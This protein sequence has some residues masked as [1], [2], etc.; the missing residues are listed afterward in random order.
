MLELIGDPLSADPPEAARLAQQLL[1][2][3]LADRTVLQQLSQR[4]STAALADPAHLEALVLAER[5]RA[6]HFLVWQR[7]DYLRHLIPGIAAIRKRQG[8][9]WVSLTELARQLDRIDHDPEGVQLVAAW[10]A[11]TLAALRQA[12]GAEGGPGA[13]L[14]PVFVDI[15]AVSHCLSFLQW[16]SAAKE[17]LAR[18]VGEFDSSLEGL[19][20]PAGRLLGKLARAV[21]EGKDR[22][23]RRAGGQS[24]LEQA[25]SLTASLRRLGPSSELLA[26]QLETWLGRQVEELARGAGRPRPAASASGDRGPGPAGK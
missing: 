18:V 6:C 15:G 7:T 4:L 10:T 13:A 1:D 26:G 14:L 8:D 3:A 23:R 19:P 12:A 16:R 11:S 21:W 17:P 5:T 9:S 25:L 22:R 20:G 2:E 24:L